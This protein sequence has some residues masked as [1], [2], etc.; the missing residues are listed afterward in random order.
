MSFQQQVNITP[1][2]GQPG[3]FATNNPYSVFPGEQGQY[4]AGAG[5]VSVGLFAW[6]QSDGR[7]IL[8]S[9]A[10]ALLSVPTGFMHRDLQAQI[11][12]YLTEYG[13]TIQPGQVAV[14]YVRGDYFAVSTVAAAVVG[15]KAFAN[16]ITGAMQPGVTGVEPGTIAITAS[17]ATNVLTVTATAGVL[18]VGQLITGAGIPANTY[19]TAQLTGTAGSTGTYSLS[20]TPGTVASE[21][22]VAHTWIETPYVIASACNIGE[23]AIISL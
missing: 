15:N 4:I 18:L 5:G 19:I 8:N 6:L 9:A 17:T 3:D 14:P 7:S 12:T 16:L 23:L 1:A 10:G 22:M 21:A 2:L 11:V 20:T 13:V